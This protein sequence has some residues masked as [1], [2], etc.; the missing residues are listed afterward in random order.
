V[1][2]IPGQWNSEMNTANRGKKKSLETEQ[3]KCL[4]F[5]VLGDF[6]IPSCFMQHYDVFCLGDSTVNLVNKHKLKLAM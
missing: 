5:L 2:D 4:Q 3:T 6:R 1:S